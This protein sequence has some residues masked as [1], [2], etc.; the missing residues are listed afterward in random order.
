[1][2]ALVTT[3][4]KDKEMLDKIDDELR[5]FFLKIII[6]ALVAVSIKLAIM[7]Q[8]VKISLFNILGSFVIGVGTAY[9]S[10]DIILHTVK[11]EYVP[12]V[13]SIIAL[14]GEKI[15]YWL[16]YS[17]KVDKLAVTAL[18]WLIGIIRK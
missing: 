8:R 14:T 16:L 11:S 1:M 3:G 4:T 13:I 10:G 9:L 15:S 18:E 5:T 12:L 2:L 17:F 7:S 6:P